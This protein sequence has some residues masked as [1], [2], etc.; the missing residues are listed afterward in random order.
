MRLKNGVGLEILSSEKLG[1]CESIRVL[2]KREIIESPCRELSGL[3][4]EDGS[5]GLYSSPVRDDDSLPQGSGKG[6]EG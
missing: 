3:C 2:K 6:K 5:W 1:Q 4:V